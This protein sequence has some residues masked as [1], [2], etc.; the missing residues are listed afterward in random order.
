MDLRGTINIHEHASSSLT[1]YWSQSAGLRDTQSTPLLSPDRLLY[2]RPLASF[3]NGSTIRQIAVLEKLIEPIATERS[4]TVAEQLL[5]LFG[6]IG[7]LIDAPA[8]RIMEALPQDGDVAK[9]IIT[10]RDLMHVGIR[11]SF[12][13]SPIKPNDPALLRYLAKSLKSRRE[14]VQVIFLSDNDLY[15]K[16]EKLPVGTCDKVSVRLRDILGRALQLNASKLIVAHNHPSGNFQPSDQDV[17]ATRKM[18]ETAV[19][20]D[21]VIIDHLIVS[22]SRIYSMREGG[23]L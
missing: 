19:V 15:I 6:T 12:I 11:E 17:F 14:C 3:S 23:E 5:S 13:G 1:G 22:G 4:K 21:L 20:L 7:A 10:G 18:V 16:D 8:D 9:L 2:D